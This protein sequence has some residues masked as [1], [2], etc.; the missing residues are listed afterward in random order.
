[1]G[2]YFNVTFIRLLSQHYRKQVVNNNTLNKV[3]ANY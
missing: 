2:I 3:G 1:M